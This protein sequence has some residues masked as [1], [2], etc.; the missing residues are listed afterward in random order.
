MPTPGCIQVDAILSQRGRHSEHEAQR[1]IKNEFMAMWDGI[2]AMGGAADERILVSCA[3]G[4]LVSAHLLTDADSS[5]EEAC[6]S[7][8][9]C[10]P[11]ACSGSLEKAMSDC[12]TCLDQSS[13][14]Q[15]TCT[16]W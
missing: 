9:S 7:H 4:S 5:A 14:Q 12:I 2:R 13:E 15:H 1:E 16:A 10:K 3:R 6:C 11:V 8:C